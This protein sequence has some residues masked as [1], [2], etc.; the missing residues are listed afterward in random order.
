MAH[1]GCLGALSCFQYGPAKAGFRLK[2]VLQT[3]ARVFVVPS[4]SRNAAVFDS[5][6]TI[7]ARVDLTYQHYLRVHASA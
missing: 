1:F 3:S 6:A 4:F 2:A 7:L 5:T